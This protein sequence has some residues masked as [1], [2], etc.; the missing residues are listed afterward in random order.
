MKKIK[1]YDGALF[2]EL[3][4]ELPYSPRVLSI[5]DFNGSQVRYNIYLEMTKMFSDY[6]KRVDKNIIDEPVVNEDKKDK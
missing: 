4:V 5:E 3:D 2:S 6:E 1:V